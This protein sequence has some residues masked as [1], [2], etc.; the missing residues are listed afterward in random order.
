MYKPFFLVYGIF[1]IVIIISCYTRKDACLDTYAT[2]FDVSADDQC[3]DGCCTYPILTLEID[4]KAGDSTFKINDTLV[5]S[6]S[7]KFRIID[8]RCYF[9]DFSLYQNQGNKIKTTES[10]SNSD[11]SVVVPD[12]IKIW[13]WADESFSP[14]TVRTFGNIDSLV[15][16]LGLSSIITNTT[17]ANLPSGHA[18]LSENTLKDDKGNIAFMTLRCARYLSKTDTINLSISKTNNPYK[19]RISKSFV[20]KKGDNITYKLKA[21]YLTLMKNV[22]L[23]LSLSDIESNIRNNISSFITVN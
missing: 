11:N 14:G 2:N 7:Q 19:F 13:R 12:D 23:K 20:T 4:K 15:F 9:S 10:I 8:L 3:S 22:D 1:V 5:N 17:F 6:F 21:D 18:L 16:Y